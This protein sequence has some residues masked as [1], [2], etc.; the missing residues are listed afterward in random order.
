MLPVLLVPPRRNLFQD[1]AHEELQKLRALCKLQQQQLDSKEKELQ[2]LTAR[3]KKQQEQ[4]QAQDKHLQG[5]EEDEEEKGQ[6]AVGTGA[7]PRVAAGCAGKTQ[8]QQQPHT[9]TRHV[10]RSQSIPKW[11]TR[12]ACNSP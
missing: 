6:V 7:G 10:S 11:P 9:L 1:T 3:C 4:R 2:A 8:R 5:G 12:T